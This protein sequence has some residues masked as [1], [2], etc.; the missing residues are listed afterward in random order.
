MG[1]YVKKM[2]M[3]NGCSSCDIPCGISDR[4]KLLFGFDGTRPDNCPMVEVSE[5]HG[6]LIDA[7]NLLSTELY[8]KYMKDILIEEGTG[9][10]YIRP[11]DV[12]DLIMDA[13]AV[14]EA[15]GE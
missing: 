14:I 5:P 2:K 11:Q 4:D 15:E 1:V 6:K 12:V 7:S 13:R 10:I 3:P 8:E 9:M